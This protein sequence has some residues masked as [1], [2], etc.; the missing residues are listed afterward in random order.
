LVG[1][2]QFVCTWEDI[3]QHQKLID[4]SKQI[5]HKAIY[6]I[7]GRVL[8]SDIGHLIETEAKNVVIE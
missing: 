4:A 5:L 6:N 1:Q 7:K 2:W 8:I 3:H